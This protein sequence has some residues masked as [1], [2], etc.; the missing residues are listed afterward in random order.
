MTSTTSKLPK[1][2]LASPPDRQLLATGVF[3]FRGATYRVNFATEAGLRTFLD[4]YLAE[5]DDAMVS[6]LHLTPQ[7]TEF[8]AASLRF[9]FN[10]DAQVAAAVVIAMDKT[11]ENHAWMTR[12]HAGRDDIVLTHDSWN[13]DERRFPPS[14]FITVEQLRAAIGQ[15]ALGDVLP[16]PAVSWVRVPHEDVGW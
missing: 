7:G 13:P 3:Y 2:R 10:R 5:A 4:H 11:Q 12:G 9:Q 6:A 16:P 14:A 1:A 8:P 15:W